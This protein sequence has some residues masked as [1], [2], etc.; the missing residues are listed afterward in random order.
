[1]KV[2]LVV[3]AVA[4]LVASTAAVA[5]SQD[6]QTAD[7]DIIVEGKRPSSTAEVKALAREVGANVDLSSPIAR[8]NQPLCLDVAG[9]KDEYHEPFVRRVTENARR[10]GLT[11]AA[12]GCHF[13]AM[14]LFAD[15]SRG[16]LQS[17]RKNQRALFGEMP[18]SEFRRLIESRDKVYA[19][20]V[21][22]ITDIDGIQLD[23]NS[24]L[25]MGVAVVR[26][27]PTGRLSPPIRIVTRSS[28][29]VIERSQTEGKTV[30]QLADYATMRLI[31]PTSELSADAAARPATIMTLFS[32]PDS[33]PDGLTAFDLAYL[34]SVYAIRPNGPSN[35]LFYQ[36][37]KAVT[38][39]AG[40]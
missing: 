6:S 8:F 1:M 30:E 25:G 21:N 20:Q 36:T 14:I 40:Q 29:V 4:G 15:D 39:Q 7:R 9:L 17:L 12:P 18:R 19:W 28:A 26:T 27:P 34:E 23:Q 11:I 35:W 3:L 33:A 16:Q 32:D 31:A 38:S 24:M 22:E 37:A 5:Q 13:N 2:T 10:A